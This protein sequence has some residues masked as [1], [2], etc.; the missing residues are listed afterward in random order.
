MK[1]GIKWAY[2][3]CQTCRQELRYEGDGCRHPT[4][5]GCPVCGGV[6]PVYCRSKYPLMGMLATDLAVFA[7][8]GKKKGGT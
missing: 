3:L 4:D 2:A 1:D 8:R 5:L 6:C 7:S